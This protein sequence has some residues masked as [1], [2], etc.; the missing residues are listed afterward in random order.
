MRSEAGVTYTTKVY[1]HVHDCIGYDC[2]AEPG[3]ESVYVIQMQ[4]PTSMKVLKK[5]FNYGMG[6]K[7]V[8]NFPFRIY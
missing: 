7:K 4:G 5:Q 1:I 2:C 8:R 3:V 6:H